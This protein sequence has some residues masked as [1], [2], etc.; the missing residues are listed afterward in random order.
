MKNKDG[1]INKKKDFDNIFKNGKSV[2]GA[3]LLL[4]FAKNDLETLRKAF[5]VSKYQDLNRCFSCK[6][7]YNL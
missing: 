1:R 3:F 6:M 4:K 2:K 7:S 5:L